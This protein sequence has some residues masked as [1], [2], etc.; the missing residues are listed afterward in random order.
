MAEQLTDKMVKELPAPPAGNRITY[1]EDVRGLGV[2]VTS[3]G[4]RAW[5]FNYRANGVERRM[6]IGE[7]N[8]WT[9]RK[10][11]DKAKELRRRVDDGGDPLAERDAKRAE[12]T[13]NMLADQFKA[14]H[15]PRK[16][17]GT[18][19]EYQRLLRIH[20]LPALGKKRVAELRHSDIESLHQKV[21][22]TGPYAANRAIAVLSKM[23]SLS[24]KWEMRTDN[25]ARGV[26]RAPEQKRERYMTPAE[27]ARLGEVLAT[28]PERTSANAVRLLLLTG[29]RKGET[30]SAQ[31]RD[32]DLEAGVWSKP[33][34][35]TKTAKLHRIPLSA[36]A[37]VLLAEM[38]AEADLEDKRRERDRLAPI[39]WLFPSLNGKPLRDVK[40][41]WAA[42]CA[43]ADLKEVRIHDLRHTYGAILA[44]AGLSLPIIGGLLGHS[45]P[46][47]TA[48]YAHLQDDPMRAATERAGAVI[49]GVGKPGDLVE[50][51]RRRA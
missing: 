49:A 34:S 22:A 32:I 26:E 41:F 7:T 45:Q 21:A 20:I 40:H 13:V 33:A 3:A 39:P 11:R 27:I 24:I 44:S 8:A 51:S 10:A 18:Q 37:R 19:D 6:T 12:P 35:T 9:V 46:G 48:R 5:I 43:R 25:P 1:D 29:A 47:T 31:W 30:L 15:L 4:T 38:R 17:A 28:H 2:R 14:E 50:I 42:V 23:L 16:R 36:P